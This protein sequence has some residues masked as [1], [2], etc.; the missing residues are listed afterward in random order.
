MPQLGLGTWP[1]DDAEVF[2]AVMTAFTL[3]YRLVDTAAQYGNEVGVGRAIAATDVPR[4]DAFVTTKLRG[5]EHGYERTLSGFEESR[6]RLA[7]DYVDLYLIHWPIPSQDLFVESW[8]AFIHLRDEGLVRS[9]GVSNFT[10][11][12]IERL[13]TETG[14][15][16]SVNQVELHPRF[17]QPDLRAFH[18]THGIA[19]EAWRPLGKGGDLADPVIAR[20]AAAHERTAAQVV[21]RWHVQLGNVTVP[22]STRQERMQENIDVFEFTLSDEDMAAIAELDDGRRLGGDPDTEVQL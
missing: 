2:D 6:R 18:Q 9:I 16:P 12:Q 8:K 4:E 10:E 21:L 14:E 1:M 11:A 7:L 5:S 3:G 17:S 19:T 20:L 13:V 15:W 22:K